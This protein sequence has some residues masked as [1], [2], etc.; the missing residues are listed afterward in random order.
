[1]FSLYIIINLALNRNSCVGVIRIRAKKRRGVLF[2]P[3]LPPFY[4]YLDYCVFSRFFKCVLDLQCR[5]YL[6]F[7]PT[8][9]LQISQ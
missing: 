8:D 7:P 1:M 2:I 5:V 9:L 4:V 6:D 3:T